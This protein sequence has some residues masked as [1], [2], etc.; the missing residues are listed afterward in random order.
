VTCTPT[1][2]P[3][4]RERR[5]QLRGLL[6]LALVLAAASLLRTALHGELHHL[7]LTPHWW[8]IW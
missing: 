7:L 8:R 3:A 2:R 1:P 6:W 4:D 5:S